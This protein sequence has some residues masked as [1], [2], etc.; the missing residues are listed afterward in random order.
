MPCQGSDRPMTTYRL[1]Q[2]DLDFLLGDA[3]LDP[4]AEAGI[5]RRPGAALPLVPQTAQLP[6]EGTQSPGG[7]G[8]CRGGDLSPAIPGYVLGGEA[9]HHGVWMQLVGRCVVWCRHTPSCLACVYERSVCTLPASQL[10]SITFIASFA[11]PRLHH[12][13]PRPLPLPSKLCNIAQH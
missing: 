7:D 10:H 4:L 8:S 1:V 9:V 11:W 5:A 13:K 12:R 6:V 2:V 3:L